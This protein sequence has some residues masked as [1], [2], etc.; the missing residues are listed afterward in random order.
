MAQSLSNVL[1]HIIFSTRDRQPFLSNNIRPNMHAYL[2]TVVR[3]SGSEC[4]IAGGV[5]DHVHLAVRLSRTQTIAELVSLLKVSSSKWIKA[6]FSDF[7]TFAWQ[8][9]YGAFSVSPPKLDALR[10]YI[11]GQEQHHQKRS[12][13]DEYRAFLVE[14]CIDFDERY[15]W[16]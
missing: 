14:C 4:Y 5:A 6:E 1:V 9:G 16:D 10:A 13:Q 2:A 8:N 15:V 11:A 3:D 12:F 7:H